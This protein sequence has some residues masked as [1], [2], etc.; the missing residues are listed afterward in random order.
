MIERP[1]VHEK[2][3]ISRTVVADSFILIVC[4]LSPTFSRMDFP[5]RL[6]RNARGLIASPV[7]VLFLVLGL[8][9]ENGRVH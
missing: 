2:G 5:T 6:L 4:Q 1:Q 9:F 8:V 3:T 7:L